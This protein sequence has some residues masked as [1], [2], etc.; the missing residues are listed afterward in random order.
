MIRMLHGSHLMLKLQF[1][2]IL[3][4]TENG[5]SVEEM[6]TIMAMSVKF[7][8]LLISLFVKVSGLIFETLGHRLSDPQT[9]Q[10]KFLD[11]VE[12]NYK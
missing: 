10:N 4:F 7:K 6:H 2:E 1:V 8:I 3:E 9:G 11:S 5:L 12:T